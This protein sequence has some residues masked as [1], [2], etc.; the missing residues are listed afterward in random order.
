ML[1]NVDIL[2]EN[3]KV[4]IKFLV[5]SSKSWDISLKVKSSPPQSLVTGSKV[6]R[7]HIFVNLMSF[8]VIDPKVRRY[9][10]GWPRKNDYSRVV[11]QAWLKMIKSYIIL[12]VWHV[13]NSDTSSSVPKSIHLKRAEVYFKA[14]GNGE[15]QGALFGVWVTL[16][17]YICSTGQSS[18]WVW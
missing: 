17:I 8:M 7:I 12:Y 13:S 10:S 2:Q 4:C 16:Y 5:S 14:P 11:L 6:V 9:F 1:T 18:H 15:S 3:M